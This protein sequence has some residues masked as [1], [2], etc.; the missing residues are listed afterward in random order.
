LAK[1]LLILNYPLALLG[2]KAVLL[3]ASKG[4]GIIFWSP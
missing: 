3:I 2:A 4:S 1:A